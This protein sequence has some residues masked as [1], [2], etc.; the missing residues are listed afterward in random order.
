[1][2]THSQALIILMFYFPTSLAKPRQQKGY[3][4]HSI[5]ALTLPNGNQFSKFF[6]DRL[7]SKF[8]KV[9]GKRRLPYQMHRYTIL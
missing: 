6:T 5:L 7:G 4:R 2:K 8:G 3:H 9:M 1:M